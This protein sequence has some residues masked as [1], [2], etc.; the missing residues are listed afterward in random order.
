MIRQFEL[1]ERV[2]GYDPTASEDLLNRGYVFAMKAHGSQQRASGDPYFSHPLEVAGILTHYRLDADTIVTALLHDTIEDTEVNRADIEEQFGPNVARLVDGVTK[3]T[4]I[5]FQSD[6]A[7]QAENFRKFVLAMSE[8]IRVLLVKLADRL[9]NM[10]TLH[11]IKRPEKRQRIAMETMDIYAPLAERIGMQEMKQE[12]EDLAFA[13]INSDARQSILKRLDFLR[14][15]GEDLIDSIITELQGLMANHG[16]QAAISGREK[17]PYS[18]WKKMQKNEVGF[19]QL[20]DIMA[21]R[22]II[23]SVE[24]CYKTL[25]IAHNAY[26]VV[27]SRFKDYISTPKPNGYRSLHTGVFGPER[28]RIELQIR[29][30]EMHDVAERGVAA[31]WNYKQ[32]GPA[33]DG[34]QYRW[35][36]ELLDI[37]EHAS[38]PEEFLEHTKLEMFQDQVFCFTPRGDLINLPHGATPVDF[39]YAVH[40]EVG[41]RCVGSKINGRMMPLRTQLLNGDQVEI[42]TSEAQTPSPTWERFVVTGKARAR[43]R[44]FVR[45]QERDEYEKLG[46][47]LLTRAFKDEGYELA[48][49]ALDGVLAVFQ[50]PTVADLCA[51]VGSGH[52]T[53][54]T[55]AE[56]V[57]PGLKSN[58]NTDKTA[59]SLA[60]AQK[61]QPNGPAGLH[62]DAVSI[63]GLIPGMAM[64][65]AGC[66]HPL[67]GDRIVGI[68]TTGRGVTVHTID[69]ETLETA[70]EQPDRWIDLSW[71]LKGSPSDMHVGR[72][73][74]SVL[75]TPG[76]LG[77]LSTVI[78]KNNGNISNLKITHRSMD[79][80]DMLIDV[81]VRNVKHL[82]D[83]I[84][85]LR[86]TPSINS[87]ERARG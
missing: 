32:G 31:H 86:A 12:L 54:R 5:E 64:H 34:P 27:P 62:P 21:F 41:D 1:V 36:R 57:Y 85:A 78:A 37:L 7:N 55:L 10:R 17:T 67:P 29:T 52:L 51:Q 38:E 43:I 81:E 14:T 40:S 15:K 76:S 28:H 33:A 73:T 25:G 24:G 22:V 45:L 47:S 48:D 87:V 69:C 74:L 9:H 79:F 70:A 77:D 82:T 84:A 58:P 56:A 6:Q 30:Q 19:E 75:N 68:V 72:I 18:I 4:R 11:F 59:V 80:F 42:I 50:Q 13:E 39:A 60:Q 20:S 26:P 65:M 2:R 49:K 66:C 46:R 16:I 44:R 3:L 35:L 63:K 23:D 61:R 71:D 83:I 8:D 53:A